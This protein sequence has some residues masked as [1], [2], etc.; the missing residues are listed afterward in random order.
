MRPLL[1][2][3]VAV[4]VAIGLLAGGG[5]LLLA[6]RDSPPAAQLR[7]GSGAGG[8]GQ[9]N[10]EWVVART[11]ESFVGYRICERLGT[12]SAPNDVVGRSKG[13]S[14][15]VAIAGG[16]IMAAQVTVDMTQLRTDQDSRDDRMREDG[17]Q[18]ARFPTATFKLARPVTL[19]DVSGGRVVDLRL[20]GVLTLHGVTRPVVF[21]LQARWDGATIQVAGSMGIRRPDFDVPH[22]AH[23]VA[24]W[25]ADRVYQGRA[26]PERPAAVGQHHRGRWVRPQGSQPGRHARL[27]A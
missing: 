6:R 27:V 21:P 12:I 9:P 10:G 15:T 17:L 23:L 14:G 5:Y 20:P 22:R 26:R 13:V 8:T 1:K 24:G 2:L 4:T 3:G 7:P 11:D 18:T 19:G 16:V 25:Q